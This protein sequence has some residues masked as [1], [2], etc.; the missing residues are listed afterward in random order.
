M[1]GAGRAGGAGGVGGADRGGACLFA[2]PPAGPERPPQRARTAPGSARCSRVC[3]PEPLGV[4]PEGR[5]GPGGEP[6]AVA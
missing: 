5:R 2:P 1:G 3:P 6:L 4:G